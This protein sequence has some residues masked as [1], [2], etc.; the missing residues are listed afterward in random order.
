M[1][2]TK[3]T[4]YDAVGSLLNDLCVEWGFCIAPAD[5]EIL[6]EEKFIEADEFACKVLIAAGM[7]P[8]HDKRW[9]KKIRNKFVEQFGHEISLNEFKHIR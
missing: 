9:R 3:H 7:H 8:E 2:K 5:A 4:M 6:K 1:D